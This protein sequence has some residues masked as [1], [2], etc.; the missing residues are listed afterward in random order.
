MLSP[1]NAQ[2][3]NQLFFD[4]RTHSHWQKKEVPEDLIKQLYDLCKWGPTSMNCCP[5]RLVFIRSQAA[6]ERLKPMLSAGNVEK[7]MAAPVTAI[8]ASD[9]QFYEHLPQLFPASATARDG[10]ANDHK[11]AHSTAFRNGTLQG[12]Y[13]ILAARC[14][15]LDCG[16]MSGFDNDA[17]DKEFFAG[18]ATQ[19]NFLVNIGYGI[20]EK[21]YA[22]APRLDFD[23]AAKIL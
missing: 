23:V 21:T 1:L 8:I 2:A 5:M 7:T 4:A 13:L 9:Y 19:S 22:R 15:G 6:K 3:L 11:K 16:P 12:A 18:T 17:V 20:G 14:L 10:F